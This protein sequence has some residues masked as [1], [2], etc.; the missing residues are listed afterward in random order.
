MSIK[1][2][3]RRAPRWEEHAS[4]L[5]EFRQWDRAH[6][7]RLGFLA[8]LQFW[9]KTNTPHSRVLL[10]RHWPHKLCWDWSMWVTWWHRDREE[11]SGS[12]R[13]S[14]HLSLYYRSIDLHFWLGSISLSWQNY[15]YMG[16]LAVK[17]PAPKIYWKHHLEQ[18]TPMGRA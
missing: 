5:D 1:I 18:A 10:S 6:R 15:G 4:N 12:R 17:P 2:D 9:G 3:L 13:L 8:G 7:K 14:L 11:Y 16:G